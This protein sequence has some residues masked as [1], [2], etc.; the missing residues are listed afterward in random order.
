[1][2]IYHF[3]IKVHSRRSGVSAQA[4]AAYRSGSQKTSS[5]L[6]SAAYRSGGVLQDKSTGETHDFT[7]K[8]G[9]EWT[10][11]LAPAWAPA[12][13]YDRQRLWNAV[14]ASETRVNSRLAREAEMSIPRELT[15]EQGRALVEGFVQEQFVRLGMV[16]D[17]AIHRVKAADG[18]SQPHA[19]VLLT[20]R[21]ISQRGFGEKRR[22]WNKVELLNSWRPAWQEACNKALADAGSDARVDH[23]TLEEQESPYL[24]AVTMRKAQH[25]SDDYEFVKKKKAKQAAVRAYNSGIDVGMI[26]R[27]VMGGM[28]GGPAG[29]V[30]AGMSEF[31][32]ELL[33]GLGKIPQVVEH[34]LDKRHEPAR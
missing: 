18:G 26:A 22:D 28:E 27:V 16:A 3:H 21:E 6:R 31:A 17:I 34:W 13:A 10:G 5:I 19:H 20:T 14:E 32:P 12:W 1:M 15:P 30:L 4:R 2:A 11:I 7:R 29:A 23:R 24:P 9:V 25:A 33:D 8:R